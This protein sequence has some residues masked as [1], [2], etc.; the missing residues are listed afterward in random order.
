MVIISTVTRTSSAALRQRGNAI[1]TALPKD[2]R[3]ACEGAKAISGTTEVFDWQESA[4][5][6]YERY[7]P[8]RYLE[9]RKRLGAL[10][11]VRRGSA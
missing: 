8:E 3:R 5:K 6:P 4:D 7:T 10:R 1:W 11:L 9:S 2:M